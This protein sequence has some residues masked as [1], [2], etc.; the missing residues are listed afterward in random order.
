MSLLKNCVKVNLA[1]MN[2]TVSGI[3]KNDEEF[4]VSK[5]LETRTWANQYWSSLNILE[6]V[7]IKNKSSTVM[8]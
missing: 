1:Y 2:I 5:A 8:K 6:K 7:T 3:K 4:K